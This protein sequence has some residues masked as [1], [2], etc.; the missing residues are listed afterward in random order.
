M[1]SHTKI[2]L[3]YHFAC[4]IKYRRTVFTTDVSKT[5]KGVCLKIEGR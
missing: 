2:L 5:V 3:L 4:P 1:K